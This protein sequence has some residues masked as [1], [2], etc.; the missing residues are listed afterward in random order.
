MINMSYKRAV[1]ITDQDVQ[2]EEFSYP[3]YRFIE[4]GFD[5]HL[6][7]TG[8]RNATDK[9]GTGLATLFHKSCPNKEVYGKV[10]VT[11][12]SNTNYR[13]PDPIQ[14]DLAII[15]G[16]WAP[17]RV[18][19]DTNVILFLQQMN[20]AGKT[21]SAICHGPQVLISAGL[22]KN[23]HMTAFIGVK[24]DMVNA[25]AIY[26]GAGT[27][28]DGNIITAD[29]YRENP[30]WVKTTLEVYDRYASQTYTVH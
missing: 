21:I 15:P 24:D 12:E 19:M 16:G 28:I 20:N 10:P 13:Y 27:F 18:R 29:H 17:E 4:E 7:L 30:T 3:M 14:F 9:S 26:R 25:G 5:V 22:C 1:I 6:W 23:R 8:D 11:L 2:P